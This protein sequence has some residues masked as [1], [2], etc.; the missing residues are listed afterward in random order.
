MRTIRPAAALAALCLL[1]SPA[2][3]D[4]INKTDGSSI[5]DVTVS[6]ETV[7][8]VT[9]R[10]GSKT[11]TVAS[12]LV[13]SIEYDKLPSLVDSAESFAKDGD[14]LNAVDQMELYVDGIIGGKKERLAWAPA[15]AMNRVMEMRMTMGDPEAVIAA[16]DRL[17]KHAPDSRFM[18]TAYL[19]KAEAQHALGR[20]STAQATLQEFQNIIE[21]KALSQLWNIE[22]RLALVLT[23]SK[24]S[25]EPKR[26]KLREI[27]GIAGQE[28][29]TV[30][31]RAKVAEGESYLEGNR[32]NFAEARK[33][34]QKVVDDPKADTAT[35]A[36]AF[37]GLGDCL[38]QD[39]FS[40]ADAGADASN[41]LKDAIEKYLRVVVLYKDQSAYRS[42]ALFFA[43]RCYEMVT[44][45][46]DANTRARMLHGMLKR[47][48]P[49]S[50]WA[51][52]A[53]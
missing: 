31:N 50:D 7:A 30:R 36:G 40:K 45:L 48:Y 27:A 1:L 18:P 22:A 35:L 49:D 26:E 23:D 25:G 42:K 11:R 12:D 41:E 32:K 39:A 43:G 2:T 14:L 24:L 51:K 28:F 4:T 46:E 34:F 10:E 15:H 29:P 37:C 38:F 21:R 47:D 20:S 16:A 52:K 33:I 9:F 5:D 3:A 8:E 44:N 13:L 6:R 17:I 19:A 53:D